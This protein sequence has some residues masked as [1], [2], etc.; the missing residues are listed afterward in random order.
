M[1]STL[2]LLTAGALLFTACQNDPKADS[3]Q[4]GA[5]METSNATGAAY[6]ADITQSQI[7]WTGTKPTGTHH[8]TF[9]LKDGNI[10]VD[11]SNVTGGK[12]DIDITSLKVNDPDTGT[13]RKLGGHLRSADFFDAEKF[14]TATFEIT[15]IKPGVD[16][17]TTKDLVM[18]DA[19]HTI[20][21]NLTMK[22][23]TKGLTFPAK[24]SVTGT[25]VTTDANFNIDRT[26]WGVDVA[27]L[28]DK[29]ISNTVNIGLHIVA[30]K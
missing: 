16:S 26:Q 22:G 13:V 12:F 4:T 5:A 10:I 19:T 28:K 6:K 9:M 18:K 25:S 2:L 11:N 21:G 1:K 8:G 15:S 23:I 7:D 24:V 29:L 17:A 30:N 27:S 3:A 14:P 20:S